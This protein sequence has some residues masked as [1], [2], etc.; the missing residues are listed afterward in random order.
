M[1]RSTLY[2]AAS[3]LLNRVKPGKGAGLQ[4]WARALKA[5]TSHKKAVV[6][7]AR[8]LA[9]LMHAIWTNGSTFQPKEAYLRRAVKAQTQIGEWVRLLL[10]RKP[11]RL[12]SVAL[13]N[14]TARI[15]WAILAKGETYRSA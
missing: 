1:L 2:E 4:A 14:K 6:A 10:E 11:S 5:R 15:A 9:V 8:K 3:S 7:L 13:A 12:V